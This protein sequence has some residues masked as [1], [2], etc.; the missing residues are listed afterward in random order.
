[1]K[2]MGHTYSNIKL[3]SMYIHLFISV[4]YF[5]D[6]NDILAINASPLGDYHS[7]ILPQIDSKLPQVIN[8]YTLNIAI[9][10]LLLSASP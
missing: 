4:I 8:E 9:Q 1:M 6:T 3:L 10:L 5:L 7:L 2:I